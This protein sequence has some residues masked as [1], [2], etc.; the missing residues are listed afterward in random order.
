MYLPIRAPW[1]TLF[2]T[3]IETFPQYVYKDQVDMMS[4]ALEFMGRPV[5]RPSIEVL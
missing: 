1:L 3:E 5:G 2:E 4:Q